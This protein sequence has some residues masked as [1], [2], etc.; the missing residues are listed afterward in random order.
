MA[1][2]QKT[3][4][5]LTE[6]KGTHFVGIR[7]YVNEQGE[8]TN[9]VVLV[10]FSYEN[11]KKA[12]HAKIMAANPVAL[13]DSTGY[14]VELVETV[15]AELAESMVKPDKARSEG[16]IN[17][18]TALSNGVKT[19]NDSGD[20]YLVGLTVRKTVLEKGVYK[21]VNS[22]DKTL[23]KNKVKKVLDLGTNKYSQMKLKSGTYAI[24]GA[25][26]K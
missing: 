13:A 21:T 8:K 22:S 1:T 14:P 26:I 23:C 5:K 25:V 17:A 16:Q 4:V 11:L 9:R 19:H 20:L 3:I 7:G 12:D 2:A 6:N 15:L 24:R 18:Y 10:G